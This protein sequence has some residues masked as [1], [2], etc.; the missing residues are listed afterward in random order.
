M[1][2]FSGIRGSCCDR[3]AR[4]FCQTAMPLAV[5]AEG[6][7]R[8]RV[9]NSESWLSVMNVSYVVVVCCEGVLPSRHTKLVSSCSV[10]QYVQ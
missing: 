10:V 2:W 4:K 9:G 5:V 8:I 7:A 1:N 3:N 6:L